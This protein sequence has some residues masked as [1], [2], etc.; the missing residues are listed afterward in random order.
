LE[1]VRKKI[2]ILGGVGMLGHVLFKKLNDLNLYEVYDITRNK[3]NRPNNFK[4][5]VTSFNS[6]FEI[7]KQINPDYI[8]N[9]VG[10]LIKGSLSDP[11]NAIL[12]NAVLPHKLVQFSEAVSAKLIHISTDCVFDGSKGSYIESDNKTAQDTYG[13]S[14]SLGEIKDSKNL[15]LRT[16]IIGPE[17]KENGEGLFS[18]FLSQNGE[19][20]G[21]T[22][23]IWGG[24]TT[25]AL[26]DVIIKCIEGDY[27]GLLHVTN[28]IPISKYNLLS[29]IKDQ[30]DLENITLI[31]VLGKKS[32]KSLISKYNYF[33]IPSYEEMISE[34]RNYL[35]KND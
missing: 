10:V 12:I 1:K 19:V 15:T 18:W 28:G 35:I 5:D 34:M 14:K 25:T 17:L 31:K 21:Y 33:D 6:L 30:F 27:I 23:S 8:I 13:L 4:R 3:E 9:C 22:G 29:L 16:S 2:L 20:N 11:S 7:I 24:V 32:D 26:S